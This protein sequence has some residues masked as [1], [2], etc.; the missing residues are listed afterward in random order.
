MAAVA[1]ALNSV[2]VIV[3]LVLFVPH[4]A[5]GDS[6]I[7]G[8]VPVL[9][10]SGVIELVVNTVVVPSISVTLY[11]AGVVRRLLDRQ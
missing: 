3:A 2:L 4:A 9:I 1:S 8:F 7:M 10:S 11:K 5:Y 6:D